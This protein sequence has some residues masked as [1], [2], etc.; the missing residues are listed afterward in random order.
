MNIQPISYNINKRPGKPKS[1]TTNTSFKGS[2]EINTLK[3]NI[4]DV[5]PNFKSK[6]LIETFRKNLIKK[7][8]ILK[9]I[10]KQIS[11]ISKLGLKR[12]DYYLGVLKNTYTENSKHSN[13]YEYTLMLQNLTTNIPD[14]V[15][16]LSF[17]GD[18]IT[19]RMF[20]SFNDGKFNK[21]AYDLF[22][23]LA[24]KNEEF[25]INFSDTQLII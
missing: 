9:E 23:K 4:K 16:K 20:T 5:L 1:Y 17:I 14:S 8:V 24:E 21:E 6:G 13:I 12:G 11:L 22:N 18:F 2:G 7:N 15:K 10:E 19:T 25:R 3:Y